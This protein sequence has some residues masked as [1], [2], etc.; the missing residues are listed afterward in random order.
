VYK[1][2]RMSNRHD[3]EHIQLKDVKNWVPNLQFKL[4]VKDV[5]DLTIMVGQKAQWLAL[6]SYFLTD[7]SILFFTKMTGLPRQTHGSH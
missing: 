4:P 7:L 1:Q 2:W 6:C 5:K 3:H